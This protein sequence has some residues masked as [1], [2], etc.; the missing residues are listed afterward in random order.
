MPGRS[1]T[2]WNAGS[3]FGGMCID[4]RDLD[5]RRRKLWHLARLGRDSDVVVLQELRG[6]ENDTQELRDYCP[7]F[8]FL[9]SFGASGATGGV[10][11]GV[12]RR[13]Q[14][15]HLELHMKVVHRERIILLHCG[16]GVVS[17]HICCFHL[18]RELGRLSPVGQ[19]ESPA[20]PLGR[21]MMGT[22]CFQETAFLFEI[23]EGR[24]CVRTGTP[25]YAQ[26]PVGDAF[27]RLFPEFAEVRQL[28]YTRRQLRYLGGAP[29]V[30][31][32]SRLDRFWSNAPT[33]IF[34]HEG[35]SLRQEHAQR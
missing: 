23:A 22:L 28:A 7:G 1:V 10:S 16:D 29:A 2:T 17:L 34:A 6:T 4:A 8:H 3:L 25:S 32:V 27:D 14:A 13:F 5:V 33:P 12:S 30:D 15:L 9:A 35:D 18:V 19:L 20:G 11:I 31:T 21:M 26:E 24:R